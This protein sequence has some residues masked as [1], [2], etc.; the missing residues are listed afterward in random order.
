MSAQADDRV[1]WQEY[2]DQLCI[3]TQDIENRSSSTEEQEIL[4]ERL[5]TAI[6]SLHHVIF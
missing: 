6:E 3:L 4:L 2:F 5:N 1:G